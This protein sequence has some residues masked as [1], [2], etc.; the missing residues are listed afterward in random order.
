MDEIEISPKTIFKSKIVRGIIGVA[1]CVIA[2]NAFT[3]KTDLGY[4]YAYQ[5]TITKSKTMI[6]TPGVHF[7]VPFF[8][9]ITTYKSA[10]TIAFDGTAEGSD[11]DLTYSATPIDVTFA[12]TYSAHVP[13][14][15]RFR[16]PTAEDEFLRMHEEFRTFDNMVNTVLVRTARDVAVSSAMQFTGEEF[17]Q[18]GMSEYR[19]GLLD[20][21]RNGI[22]RTRFELVEIEQSGLAS[23]TRDQTSGTQVETQTTLVKKLV[24]IRD[25]ETGRVLRSENPLA[26][27]GIE[28]R[29]VNVTGK[30]RPEPRFAEMLVRNKDLVAQRI[31]AE[32]EQQTAKAEAETAQLREEIAKNRAIQVANREKEVAVI[33]E[34]RKVEIE[35]EKK[36]Y[37]LVLKQKEL[38]MAEADRDIQKAADQAATYQASKLKKVGFAEADVVRAH[39]KALQDSKDIY[40]AEI[41]KDKTI[42]L[43]NNLKD[44]KV[45][46]PDVNIQ[47]VEGSPLTSAGVIQDLLINGM[48]SGTGPD[49]NR[50][51][52]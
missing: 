45:V 17:I 39:Y 30:P 43:A 28:V 18:G 48:L 9:R 3:W 19:S 7:K 22:W 47:G 24:P 44:F 2:F 16:I 4:Q 27:Y 40:L 46:M 1:L 25:E 15:F 6:S 38:E 29:Q 49:K 14:A 12:D 8:N 42:A 50:L 33:G 35:T 20:Q 31:A 21:L 13:I 26:D 36:A 37:A 32:Q 34:R 51:N 52:K 10:I 23:V 41:D 11:K 5:N